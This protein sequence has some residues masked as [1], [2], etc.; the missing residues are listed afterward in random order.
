M[1]IRPM[2]GDWEITRLASIHLL[3]HRTWVELPIP[4]RIGSLF[5]DLNTA[6]TRIALHGSVQGDQAREDFMTAVRQQFRAAEPVTFVADIVTATEVQYVVI[7]TLEFEEQGNLPDELEYRVVLRESPPPPPPPSLLGDLD[8][9]L[10]DQAQG[11]MDSV[12]GALDAIEALGNIPDFG[13]PTPPLRSALD[14][15][16]S[17]VGEL[18]S[19][20]TDL[21]NLLGT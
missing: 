21:Q 7:E 10:L 14:G 3:E 18:G 1:K 6:P 16:T 2:L 4:G 11:L 20:V 15:V 19:I 8:S 12:T 17:T 9:G 13:D 5:Q